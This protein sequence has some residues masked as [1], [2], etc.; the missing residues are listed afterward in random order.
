MSL[1][2][3]V[4]ARIGALE[5]DVALSAD[6]GEI[7]AVLGPNGAGKSTLLRCLAGLLPI[8]GGRIALDGQVLDSP[9]TGVFVPPQRRAVS[10]VFQDYLLFPSLSVLENVAFGLRARG[11][12][13]RDA[14]AAATTWLERVGLAERARSRPGELSGGQAQRV[15]LAR[16]MATQPRL[17]LLDEPLA[18]LDATTR[19]DLRRDLRRH[20]SDSGGVRL[21][22]THDPVDAYALADRMIVM[23]DGRVVQSGTLAEVTAH[24]RS[25]YVADLVGINL[26]AGVV[27]AGRLETANGSIVIAAARAGGSATPD[28]A[29][30]AAIRPGSIALHRAAPG[31][32]P[33]NAW[34]CTVVD[35]DRRA[36]RVRVILAGPLDL[37]AEITS[38][39]LAG[40][41]LRPGDAV[42]ASVKATEVTIYAA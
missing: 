40:L 32:S 17:L 10:V 3:D 41:A 1:V 2:A 11:T 13:A 25:P 28:G 27:R 26:V 18:A 23:E 14:R 9:T 24:P 21:L 34:P 35:V 30:F 19:G 22:V 31:G 38:D 12:H 16:A 42:H 7:V 8:D 39:A 4:K 29:A 6:P 36:D 33:R 20:L 37:V 5:L 15:A